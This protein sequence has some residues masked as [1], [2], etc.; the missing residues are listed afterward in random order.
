[1]G[2]GSVKERC[3]IPLHSCHNAQ[4]AKYVMLATPVGV[5]ARKYHQSKVLVIAS[6]VPVQILW[7]TNV[8]LRRLQLFPKLGMIVHRPRK[9]EVVNVYSE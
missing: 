9:Q 7:L 3:K 1:M 6:Q 5:H 2:Q 8:D 4:Y